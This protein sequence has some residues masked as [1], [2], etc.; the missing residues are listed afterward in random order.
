VTQ[1]MGGRERLQKIASIWILPCNA[2]CTWSQ[3]YL[4]ALWGRYITA[5]GGR[6]HVCI[7]SEVVLMPCHRKS[8]QEQRKP[9]LN[10]LKSR[11]TTMPVLFRNLSIHHVHLIFFTCFLNTFHSSFLVFG[12]DLVPCTSSLT[13]QFTIHATVQCANVSTLWHLCC[14]AAQHYSREEWYAAP[15]KRTKT[16]EPE[17]ALPKQERLFS[18]CPSTL[19]NFL[20]CLLLFCHL[21]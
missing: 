14:S 4:L 1:F 17:S 19:C 7:F 9:S 10:R 3:H 20:P 13:T 8:T 21:F 18:R 15:K 2:S 5:D 6:V 16:Q 12:T 11:G